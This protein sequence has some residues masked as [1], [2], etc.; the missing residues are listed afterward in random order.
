MHKHN[1]ICMCLK[2]V[3]IFGNPGTQTNRLTRTHTQISKYGELWA[4]K[5]CILSGVATFHVGNLNRKQA[6]LFLNLQKNVAFFKI[7][8]PKRIKLASLF[9]FFSNSLTLTP[10]HQIIE[11]KIMERKESYSLEK[12]H[13]IHALYHTIL[14]SLDS[15][16][17]DHASVCVN[18]YAS[19]ETLCLCKSIAKSMCTVYTQ[20]HPCMVSCL[21]K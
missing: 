21:R 16:Y 2:I 7:F 5:G 9:D 1:I 14:N 13:P 11:L 6:N 10:L 3:F 20:S 19:K 15:F 12:R 8:D 17:D 4:C 18:A